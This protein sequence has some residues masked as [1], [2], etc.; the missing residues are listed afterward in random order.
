MR[1]WIP[2]LSAI[3]MAAG[4]SSSGDYSWVTHTWTTDHG[5]FALDHVSRNKVDVTQAV[6]RT[7]LG[8]IYYFENDTNARIFDR[9]P[10]AYAYVDNVHLMGRPDRTDQN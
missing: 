4:C 10:A 5:V 7:Y 8:E 3:L 9:R 6:R 2:I 1:Q